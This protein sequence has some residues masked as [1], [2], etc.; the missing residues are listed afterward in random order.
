MSTVSDTAKLTADEI[1]TNAEAGYNRYRSNGNNS[2]AGIR[3][4]VASVYLDAKARMETL[5]ATQQGDAAA[6]EAALV[7]KVFGINDIA[8]NDP[9]NRAAVS[10]SYRD[11]SERASNA[12]TPQEAASLLSLANTVGDELLARAV[13]QT[14]WSNGAFGAWRDVLDDFASTRPAQAAAL[15]EI[16]QLGSK[17]LDASD[18]FAFMLPSPSE[19]ANL[20]DY[21]IA[22]LAANAA[23]SG[24]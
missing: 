14:A 24:S 10:M 16:D 13:A 5:A 11:A 8:G 20:A 12:S 17:T 18:L 7:T 2:P 22:G 9:V 6:V 21:Q 3:A 19:L 23:Q 4:G 15:A 1:R